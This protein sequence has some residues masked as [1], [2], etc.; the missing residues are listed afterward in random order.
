MSSIKKVFTEINA[1]LSAN[2]GK[3]VSEVMPEL[4]AMMSA[5]VTN[6][7]PASFKNEKGEVIAVY[8]YYHKKW[9][10]VNQHVYGAK[11]GTNTGLNSMCKLGVNQWTK[12]QR[13]GKKAEAELLTKLANGELKVE[14]LVEARQS[15]ED[16]KSSIVFVE[17][18]PIAFDTLEELENYLEDGSMPSTNEE[19][20]EP[21]TDEQSVP[22]TEVV[23]KPKK[24]RKSKV[25]TE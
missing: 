2:Q 11:S 3:L 14:D 10:L 19:P 25:V 9:E 5:K 22:Q 17:S 4:L 23:E 13:E 12:Q 1:F 15:I 20:A 7:G 6:N 18:Y 24:T 8:C 16:K 21:K